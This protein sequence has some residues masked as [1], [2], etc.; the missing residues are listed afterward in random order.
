MSARPSLLG[1]RLAGILIFLGL[2]ATSAWGAKGRVANLSA[3]ILSSSEVVV[4]A[5]LIQWMTPQLGEEIN[6]GIP[7]DIYFYI[8][9]KKRQMGWFDEEVTS[10]TI[11][12]TIKFDTLKK[13]YLITTRDADSTIQSVFDTFE[14]A[15]DLISTLKSVKIAADTRLKA[16]HT[17][18]ASVK[19]EMKASNV[20]FVLEYILFFIPV[21]E[22]DTPWADSAPFYA[23]ASSTTTAPS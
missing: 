14:R 23:P 4:S 10:K 12:H 19:A 13:Q 17:Y 1:F 15:A 18:Y 9:I 22:L 20:P 3:A 8:L 16:R 21:L 6:N 2:A 7:K 5:D 11:R